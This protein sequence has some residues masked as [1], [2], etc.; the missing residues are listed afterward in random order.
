MAQEIKKPA[1]GAAEDDIQQPQTVEALEK[2][3]LGPKAPKGPKEKKPKEKKPVGKIEVAVLVS[4]LWLSIV[5]AFVLLVLFDP[6]PDLMIRGT[7]LL[8]LNPDEDTRE[9]YFLADIFEFQEWERELDEWEKELELRVADLD[10]REEELDELE[11]MLEEREIEV[12]DRWETLRDIG[13]DGITADAGEAAKTLERM[14][15]AA[16]ANALEEMDFD[17]AMRAV[18]LMSAKRRAPIFNVMDPE[19]RVEFLEA[20]AAEPE[21]DDYD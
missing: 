10:L 2:E 8:R 9:D 13:V 4:L 18:M 5:S 19:M 1:K 20:M 21:Y 6:T 15:P 11:F 12:E 7:V 17:S 14:Q 3:M 16:A